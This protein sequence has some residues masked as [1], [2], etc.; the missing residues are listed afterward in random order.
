MNL[1]N[2]FGD[3]GQYFRFNVD[4]GLQDITLSDWEKASNI[5]AQTHNYLAENKRAIKRF[6]DS[7]TSKYLPGRD[8][9]G[10]ELAHPTA[11]EIVQKIYPD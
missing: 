11:G 7:L 2:R 6:V 4:Q 10:G 1:D 5:S 8:G 3:D 9:H